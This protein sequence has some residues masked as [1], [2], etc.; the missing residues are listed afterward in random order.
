MLDGKDIVKEVT[1]TDK[2]VVAEKKIAGD[3][4][5]D[6]DRGGE[7]FRESM[8]EH[9]TK[10]VV[11]KHEKAVTK[12]DVVE[13]KDKDFVA[14]K[15]TCDDARDTDMREENLSESAQESQRKKPG[16]KHEK[17]VTRADVV[18]EKD[19][20]FVAE[21]ETEDT[22]AVALKIKVG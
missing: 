7:K 3:T 13:E 15:E 4:F 8:Q 18:E 1:K 19:K 10:H 2:D 9:H 16:E 5:S 20:D 21:K 12:A 22:E 6:S 17:A 14:E 11:E